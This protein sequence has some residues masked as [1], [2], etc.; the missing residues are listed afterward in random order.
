MVTKLSEY[1]KRS[2][3]LP[4]CC[5]LLLAIS[6]SVLHAELIFSAPPRE[7]ATKGN[8]TYGPLVNY[9]SYIIGEKVI[10][11]H[12]GGWAEYTTNMRNGHYD[13][14]FDA[15]HFGAWRMKHISHTP[16]ARLPGSL[17]FVVVAKKNQRNLNT[18]KDLLSV[19]VCALA[20]PNL[21]TVTLYNLL[22][23]PVY[24]PRIHEVKGG[25]SGVFLSLKNGKCDAA[26][27]RDSFYYNMD[28]REKEQLRVVTA[29][30]PIPNQTITVSPRLHAKKDIIAQRLVSVEGKK[31]ATNLLRRFSGDQENLWLVNRGE[32]KDL[33]HLLTGVV[34][35]W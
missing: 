17:G 10:Y 29:S 35:G 32:F 31:A 11:E 27:L 34:F 24:Q 12:P 8:E 16:V 13:I 20:S 25:F 3:Y 14:V 28:P 6:S 15:P 5:F 7:N 22:G 30:N 23:N 33:D 9:L 26:V 18:I 21:G 1:I 19:K 2:I 4:G